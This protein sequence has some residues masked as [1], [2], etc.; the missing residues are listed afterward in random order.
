MNILAAAFS[1]LLAAPAAAAPAEP[2]K[3]L[4]AKEIYQ[5]D[6][7]SVVLILAGYPTGQGELGLAA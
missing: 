4:S 6:A 1:V 7:P 3:T 2:A 5:K